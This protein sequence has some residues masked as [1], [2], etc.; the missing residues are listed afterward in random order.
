M[1]EETE[2][3]GANTGLVVNGTNHGVADDVLESRA[4]VGVEE[5]GELCV[6]VA[7]EESKGGENYEN[8]HA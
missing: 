8:A 3:G 5:R 1:K 7:C 6:T 4:S 2:K